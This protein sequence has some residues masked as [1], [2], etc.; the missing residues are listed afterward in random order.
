MYK[1]LVLWFDIVLPQV[2]G[3]LVW[4]SLDMVFVR[5]FHWVQMIV[6]DWKWDEP[7]SIVSHMTIT[8]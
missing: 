2:Y 1:I 4:D 5:G 3:A 8:D 7:A 6:S